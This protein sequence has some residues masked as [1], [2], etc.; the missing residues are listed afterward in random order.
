MGTEYTVRP[1]TYSV[2]D[3]RTQSERELAWILQHDAEQ[4]QPA[5]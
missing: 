1:T 4:T 3:N 2:N 5:V